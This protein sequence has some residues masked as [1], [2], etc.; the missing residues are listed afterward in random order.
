MQQAHDWGHKAIA[1]TDH[2]V[3]QAFTDANHY[4][5]RLEKD[6]SFK[7]IYGV[8]GYLVDDL[9]EVAVKEKGQDYG[10]VQYICKSKGS[11]SFPNYPTYQH[12]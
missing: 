1:I 5:E 4:I 3:V 8:E 12:Q 10:A 9:K 7:I 6:D 11:D 2:G